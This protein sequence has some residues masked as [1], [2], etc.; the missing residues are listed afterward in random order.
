MGK[1]MREFVSGSG[2]LVEWAQLGAK[3]TDLHRLEDK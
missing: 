3:Q 1:R 2:G